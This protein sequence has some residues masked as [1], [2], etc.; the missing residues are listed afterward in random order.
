MYSFKQ[1]VFIT[2]FSITRK[3]FINYGGDLEVIWPS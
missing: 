1:N 3:H 2:I